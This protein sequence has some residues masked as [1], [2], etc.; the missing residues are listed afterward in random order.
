MKE[1]EDEEATKPSIEQVSS[2]DD[3]PVEDTTAAEEGAAAVTESWQDLS[4]ESSVDLDT[5]IPDVPVEQ[6][7]YNRSSS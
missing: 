7:S 4:T 2:V 6:P 1:D 5:Q 3:R